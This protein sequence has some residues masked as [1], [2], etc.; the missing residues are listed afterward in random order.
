MDFSFMKLS[1]IILCAILTV[2]CCIYYA[3][4]WGVSFCES[5]SLCSIAFKSNFHS[6]LKQCSKWLRHMKDLS[7]F[8][9]GFFFHANPTFVLQYLGPLSVLYSNGLV[10][11][12]SPW[13]CPWPRYLPSRLPSSP[14]STCPSNSVTPRFYYGITVGR[15]SAAPFPEYFLGGVFF[16]RGRSQWLRHMKVL[17]VFRY[18]FFFHAISDIR[19]QYL[20]PLSVLYSNGLA[21]YPSPWHCPWPRYLPSRICLRPRLVLVLQTP[22]LRGL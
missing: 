13:H 18:G 11:Y 10:R 17:S 1:C 20:G 5:I 7:V 14:P 3:I 19:L 6:V 4:G 22:L 8:R 21:R 16:W 9:Y 12:P 2:T 15:A